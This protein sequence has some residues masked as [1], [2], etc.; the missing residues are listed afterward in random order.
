[1]LGAP[2]EVATGAGQL[3][4]QAGSGQA[5]RPASQNPRNTPQHLRTHTRTH[6][7]THTAHAHHARAHAGRQA[8]KYACMHAGAQACTRARDHPPMFVPCQARCCPRTSSRR[9]LAA[10]LIGRWFDGQSVGLA[11]APACSGS[12]TSTLASRVLMQRCWCCTELICPKSDQA[13]GLVMDVVEVSLR[14]H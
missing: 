1:M 3:A 4:R 7:H 14:Y 13:R 10:R 11:R 6:T 12:V 5:A 9:W 8:Q 2:T